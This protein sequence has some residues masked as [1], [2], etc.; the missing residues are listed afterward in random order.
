MYFSDERKCL[1]NELKKLECMV[2]YDKRI[3]ALS[4]DSSRKG[5]SVS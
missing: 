1:R 5:K 3:R 4:E 2:N